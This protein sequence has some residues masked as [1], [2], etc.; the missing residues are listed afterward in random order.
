[1]P[2]HCT[3]YKLAA[4]SAVQK[5]FRA[6]LLPGLPETLHTR[7]FYF[8]AGCGSFFFIYSFI[9]AFLLALLRACNVISFAASPAAVHIRQRR[10]MPRSV[11]AF[12]AVRFINY[13]GNYKN[14]QRQKAIKF[15]KSIVIPHLFLNG[16]FI[17]FNILFIAGN[18][19]RIS[20]S[21]IML[22]IR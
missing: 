21:A 5:L 18:H 10:E 14:Q 2:V 7:A 16:I 4:P 6:V 8:P 20:V 3:L 12:F 17:Y 15:S 9:R 13:N 11:T 19:L 1:M 22:F